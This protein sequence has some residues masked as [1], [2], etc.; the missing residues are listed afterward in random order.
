MLSFQTANISLPCYQQ[1][2]HFL[3]FCE[4]GHWCTHTHSMWTWLQWYQNLRPVQYK[5]AGRHTP[6]MPDAFTHIP[7]WD[8]WSR[9]QSNLSLEASTPWPV[10]LA[11]SQHLSGL[12][13]YIFEMWHANK[14]SVTHHASLLVSS[15]LESSSSEF[16]HKSGRKA[17]ADSTS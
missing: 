17:V 9:K 16:R 12:G 15:D 3:P 13:P 7:A 8:M 2:S 10:G 6:S 5:V 11:E 1:D 4:F 14:T